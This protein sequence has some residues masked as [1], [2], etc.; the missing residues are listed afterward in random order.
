MD[1]VPRSTNIPSATTGYRDQ[2]AAL[3]RDLAPIAQIIGKPV[4]PQTMKGDFLGL[5]VDAEHLVAVCRFLRDQLGFE[6][7]S[8]VS[9]VDMLDH[10]EVVYH[11]RSIVR[12]QLLQVKV[13]IDR[14]KPVVDSVVSVWPTANWLERET[15]DMYGIHFAGH[16]DLRRMLLDDDFEG[17]PLRK[18]FH[19]VPLTVKPRATTQVDPNMAVSGQFQQQRLERVVQKKLGQGMQ[20][21]L[22]PG[23]PTFGHSAHGP[24][25]TPQGAPEK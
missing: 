23:T 16:P 4:Q 2:N 8:C 17:Y 13:R 5:E 15:Y 10:M 22:H 9:G 6:L 25:D 20:E 1:L 24:E 7:L 21:R 14:E 12:G 18:D 19:Q 11:V 3:A